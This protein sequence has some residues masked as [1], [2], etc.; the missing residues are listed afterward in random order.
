M[1]VR[2]IKCMN[3]LSCLESVQL[4]MVGILKKYR[5]TWQQVLS[6]AAFFLVGVRFHTEIHFS[7]QIPEKI[8]IIQIKYG[9]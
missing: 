8:L 4:R 9:L 1:N 7:L 3:G 2:F 6:V 5:R